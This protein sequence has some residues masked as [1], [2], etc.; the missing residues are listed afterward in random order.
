MKIIAFLTLLSLSASAQTGTSVER[1][2]QNP[3]DLQKF[4]KAKGPS[5]SG[6]ADTKTYFIKPDSKGRYFYFFL[7][8]APGAF[9]YSGEKSKKTVVRSGSGFR[10][11]TYKPLGKYQDDYFDPTETLVEVE[12]SYNDPDLPELAFV[13]LDTLSVKLALGEHFIRQKDSF[14]Y[15][16]NNSVL[17]LNIREGKVKCLKYARISQIFSQDNV[18]PELLEMNCENKPLR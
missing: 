17:L 4:K 6:L 10:M 11:V 14:I 2:L 7:F 5:N 15:A 13:G 9:V 3:F 16:S 1:L 12:A 8:R 18:S